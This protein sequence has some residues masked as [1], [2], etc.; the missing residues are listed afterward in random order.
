[1]IMPLA[2]FDAVRAMKHSTAGSITTTNIPELDRELLRAETS[3]ASDAI[4]TSGAR[5][6][7]TQRIAARFGMRARGGDSSI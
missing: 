1:M 7:F 6:S 2:T 4:G 3:I 5:R